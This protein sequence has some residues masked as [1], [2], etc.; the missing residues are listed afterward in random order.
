LT[1]PDNLRKYK[2]SISDIEEAVSKNNQNSGGNILE[3]G[4]QGFAVRGLGTIK[5]EKILKISY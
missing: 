4:G 5:T 2:L 1:N 3:R